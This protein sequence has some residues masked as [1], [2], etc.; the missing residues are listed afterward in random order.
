MNRAEH[1][2]AG[3]GAGS[4]AETLLALGGDETCESEGAL[5]SVPREGRS[6]EESKALKAESIGLFAFSAHVCGAPTV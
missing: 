3:A 2:A 5:A 4:G 1:A 6:I